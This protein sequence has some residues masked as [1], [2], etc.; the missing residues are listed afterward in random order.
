MW[1][2]TELFVRDRHVTASIRVLSPEQRQTIAASFVWLATASTAPDDVNAWAWKTLVE[3]VLGPHM[4]LTVDHDEPEALDCEWW[5]ETMKQVTAVFIRVNELEGLIR[6]SWP[7]W[8]P[9][10]GRTVIQ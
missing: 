5:T 10:S 8:P 9:G 1:T 2:D 6:G 4:A 7:S 3:D